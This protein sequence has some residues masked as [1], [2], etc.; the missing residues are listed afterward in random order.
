V[1]RVRCCSG[2]GGIARGGK[3]FGTGSRTGVVGG[4]LAGWKI[5]SGI[6]PRDNWEKNVREIQ[7]LKTRGNSTEECRTSSWSRGEKVEERDAEGSRLYTH[8][9]EKRKRD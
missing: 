9:K 1:G 4:W 7:S 5:S 8:L 3:E 6:V 2:L